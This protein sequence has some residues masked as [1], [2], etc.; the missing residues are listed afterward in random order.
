MADTGTQPMTT[1]KPLESLSSPTDDNNSTPNPETSQQDWLAPLPTME[2][3]RR[4]RETGVS[5]DLRYN[6]WG[7]SATEGDSEYT[8]PPPRRIPDWV[9]PLG[10]TQ[11]IVQAGHGTAPYLIHAR[12]VLDSPSPDPTS[13][14][15]K[16]CTLSIVEIDFCRDL[17]CDIKIKK[18]TEAYFSSRP[19]G[20][21]GDG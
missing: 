11:S 20:N 8:T 4:R 7:L 9:L 10:E 12:G 19:S 13:F 6:H 14:D 1:G 15:R 21:I 17:G 5:Q 2:V 18:K 16:Q 3:I